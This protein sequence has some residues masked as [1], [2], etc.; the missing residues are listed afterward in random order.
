MTTNWPDLDAVQ[1]WDAADP[2]AACRARFALP[3]GTIYLD[4]NSLGA[5]P[6]ATAARV[7]D[8]VT[9]Q[10]G[11]DLIASWN[12]HGWIEAPAR[13]GARIAPLIG[14]SPDEVIVADSTSVNLFK[15]LAAA[16]AA[17]HDR[18]TI[19]AEPG[20]FPTDLYVANGVAKMMPGRTVRTVPAA[21]IA[22][23]IDQDT[24][25]VLLTHVHYKTGAMLDMAGITAAAHRAGA[26]ILWDLSHSAGAVELDLNGCSVDLAIGCGYKYLNGGPGAP[27]FLFVARALQ[28]TL[29][30]PLSGWM[31]HAAPFDFGDEYAPAPGVRRFLCGTPPILAMSAL[32]SGL[33][34][35]NGTTLAQLVAKSRRLGDLL[36]AGIEAR[37]VR[38]GFTL[39]TPR[40][41]LARGSHVSI[42]HPHAWEICQALIARGVVGD[43]RAPDVLRLGLTP[44]YTSFEDVWQAVDRLA[45]VMDEGAWRDPAFAERAAVT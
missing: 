18:S 3:V 22:T 20:N 12:K 17:R 1:S 10:W 38:H 7:A 2:L 33:D 37:C 23:A 26:L 44:L 27:A 41:P 13:L 25:V 36:I 19:L 11:T 42:A 21:Q 43:F 5:L 39:V 14:A 24:A 29:S 15:L 28:Q 32:E 34:T 9:R 8:A 40:D 45:A 6:R 30:S 35:F 31:G 4:G 16:C